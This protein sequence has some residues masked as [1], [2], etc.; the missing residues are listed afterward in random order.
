VPAQEEAAPAAGGQQVQVRGDATPHTAPRELS[1]ARPASE[2]RT[3]PPRKRRESAAPHSAPAAPAAAA[4][5][6]KPQAKRRRPAP[7]AA[8]QDPAIQIEDSDEEQAPPKKQRKKGSTAREFP[9]SVRGEFGLI[10]AGNVALQNLVRRLG[11]PDDAVPVSRG[12]G[13]V[14]QRERCRRARYSVES[15]G[16]GACLLLHRSHRYFRT[17]R[18]SLGMCPCRVQVGFL[19]HSVDG[20]GRWHMKLQSLQGVNVPATKMAKLAADAG[21]LKDLDRVCGKTG[22]LVVF[23]H[24]T[25][26]GASL[27]L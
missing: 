5:A 16:V 23:P 3:G 26:N 21:G 1:G 17:H 9:P 14:V 27:L 7:E 2:R 10:R 13:T 11:V 19:K 24:G 20:N 15:V 25:A 6:R 22:M 18:T 12:V 8:S 4:A